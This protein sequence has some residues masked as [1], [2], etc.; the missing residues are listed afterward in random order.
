[1]RRSWTH[2]PR[3]GVAGTRGDRRLEGLND[4]VIAADS[5]CAAMAEGMPT[6]DGALVQYRAMDDG[7]ERW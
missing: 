1:M 3:I 7:A 5:P 6:V 2:G 4:G